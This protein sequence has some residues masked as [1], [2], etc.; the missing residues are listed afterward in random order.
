MDGWRKNKLRDFPINIKESALKLGG[1]DF[2]W[3]AARDQK[4]SEQ[5]DQEIW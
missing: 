2:G 1:V 4:I 3:S 5:K